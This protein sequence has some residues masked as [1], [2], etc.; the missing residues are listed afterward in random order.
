[1]KWVIDR[2]EDDFAVMTFEEF[3]FDVP[4]KCLPKNICEGAVVDLTVD[5]NATEA[6]AKKAR[7]LMDS[8][9]DKSE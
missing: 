7:S 9:F 4:V 5:N 1:M 6:K 3:S 2:I 8:L